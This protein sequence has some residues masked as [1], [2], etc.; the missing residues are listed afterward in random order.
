VEKRSSRQ[1]LACGHSVSSK[2][3]GIR[4]CVILLCDM[5]FVVLF[6]CALPFFTLN[7]TFFVDILSPI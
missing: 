5:G 3:L 6:V 1:K 2:S 4:Y 7:A